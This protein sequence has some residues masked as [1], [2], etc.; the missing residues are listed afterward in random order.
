L[1]MDLQYLYICDDGYGIR[2]YNRNDV[3]KM[4]EVS[5]ITMDHPRDIIVLDHS[6]LVISD[7]NFIQYDASDINNIKQIS[8]LN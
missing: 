5:K 4:V 2:V 1:G 6:L 8:I 7:T 3:S